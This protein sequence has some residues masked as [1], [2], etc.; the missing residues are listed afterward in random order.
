MKELRT[1]RAM[2]SLCRQRA[3]F[4]PEDSWKHLAEA[5]MWRHRA[6]DL[7]A[8]HHVECNQPGNKAAA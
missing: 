7:V 1:C 6:M 3:S 2:E 4:Y 5:E 8:E